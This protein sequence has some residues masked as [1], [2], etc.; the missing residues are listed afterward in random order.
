MSLNTL[1]AGKQ[2]VETSNVYD[3][4]TPEIIQRDLGLLRKLIA[5]WRVYPD[6]FVDYLCSLNPNNTFKFF[7]YQRLYLRAM[8][9]YK[10]CYLV[11]PRGFSKSFLAVLALMIKC[12]LYPGSNVFVVS[13]G[14]E[15]SAGILSSKINELCRLIPALEKEIIWDTRKSNT[16][17][18]RDTRDSAVYTFRNHSSLENVAMTEKT[19]GRRFQSGLDFY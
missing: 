18:T 4:I 6:K 12:I 17:R 16:A 13:G 1:L 9:R 19:R 5:Y 7:F 8:L 10:H 15:Q 2:V 3:E 11:C 14:K